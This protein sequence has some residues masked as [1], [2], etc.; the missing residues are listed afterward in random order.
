MLLNLIFFIFEIQTLKKSS[1][2]MGFNISAAFFI[3]AGKLVGYLMEGR[4]ID[5]VS[6]KHENTY[7]GLI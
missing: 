7:N 1:F 3:I 2:A 6:N 5:K 4:I